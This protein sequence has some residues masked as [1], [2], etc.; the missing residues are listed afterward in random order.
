MSTIQSDDSRLVFLEQ[1]EK[2]IVFHCRRGLEASY[3]IA[4]ALRI[5]IGQELFS[6][7]GYDNFIDYAS[8]CLPFD[9]RT[10][11]RLLDVADTID[12][13]KEAGLALPANESQIAELARLNKDVQARAWEQIQNAAEQAETPITVRVVRTAVDLLGQS[14][15]KEPPKEPKTPADELEAELPGRGT[16]GKSKPLPAPPKRIMLS[17]TGEAALERIGRLC[18]KEASS[19]IE[20][21]R[22]PISERELTKWAQQDN[23]MVKSLGHYVLDQRWSVAK[24]LAFEERAITPFTPL[25]NLLAL[26]RAHQGRYLVEFEGFDVRIEFHQ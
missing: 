13:L 8:A 14:A 12:L 18:G 26:A 6:E 17:E 1:Q 25:G 5:I 21:L 23:E 15:P 10:A 19:A 7:R 9:S 24:A 16:D 4:N 2:H 3:A 11:N 22:V 20:E